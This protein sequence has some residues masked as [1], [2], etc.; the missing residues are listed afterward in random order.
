MSLSM[1]FTPSGG[2]PITTCGSGE[3]KN[4]DASSGRVVIIP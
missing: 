2:L 1:S 3:G 4:V